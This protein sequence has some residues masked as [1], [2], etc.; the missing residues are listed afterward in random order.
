MIT[1]RPRT[2][3]KNSQE[4]SSMEEEERRES[5]A[6]LAERDAEAAETQKEPK[7]MSGAKL[8]ACFAV[9]QVNGALFGLVRERI[10]A[11]HHFPA[12]LFLVG[13]AQLA[14]L[15][16]AA[17]ICAVRRHSYARERRVGFWARA[18]GIRRVPLLQ[19]ALMALR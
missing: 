11:Q 18:K 9:V 4:L 8:A 1:G 14:S 19:F 10:L 15:L 13:A 16:A 12:P 5:Q 17:L 7:W 2:L 6:A 3:S